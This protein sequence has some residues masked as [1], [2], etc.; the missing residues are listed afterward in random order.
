MKVLVIGSGGREHALVKSFFE[1]AS[2]KKVFVCPG[3][4]GMTQQ[5]TILNH[6]SAT[7]HFA[8]LQFCQTEKI[9]FVFIGPEEPLVNGLSD[10][11]RSAGIPVVGP[12]QKAAQ[13]EGSKIFAKQF[14]QQ[15]HVATADAIVVD[16]VQGTLTAAQ[17][18][19]K[20][21]ILKADGLAGGKG[22]FICDSIE[23][24]QSAAE[25]LFVHQKLGSAGK[26]ALLEK[27]LPGTEL[28]FLVITNGTDFQTL[29]L[30]QD[31][32]RLL[33]QN[34]GPNTGGMGT[35]AP[36][37]IPSSL[38]EKIIEKIIQPSIQGLKN[39]NLLYRG[40]L[41]VGVMVVNKEPYALE[42]NVRFGDP[43]TQVI[44]PLLKNDT[45]EL[46]YELAQGNLQKIELNQL[47]AFCIVNAA[48]GYPDQPQKNAPIILPKNE[49][50]AYVLHAA[51]RFSSNNELVSNGG[52]VLNVV[53]LDADRNTAR[54]KAYAL[55]EKIQLSGRQ[56]RTDLGDYQFQRNDN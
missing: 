7:D 34:K 48:A 5:A 31:H 26:R 20:P 13:L 35:V 54:Q 16:S 40:I 15:S 9:D 51:T 11:L 53:A 41:F 46:F 19:S 50:S 42:Y 25:D 4:A 45:A 10:I 47:N 33:D 52:R 43:E 14:M 55:N 38:Y 6:I 18:H 2:V 8:L 3:N 49:P 30:A 37:Q 27:N 44:L 56:Y 17:Q 29:P 22:V 23:E 32:K 39:N 21:Y 24:L 28:S 1:S 12:S 36:L